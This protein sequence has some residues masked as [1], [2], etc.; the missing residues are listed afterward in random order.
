[1]TESNF[2]LICSSLPK[3]MHWQFTPPHNYCGF[4]CEV[5]TAVSIQALRAYFPYPHLGVTCVAV[6][7]PQIPEAESKI[8]GEVVSQ[9]LWWFA[10]KEVFGASPWNVALLSVLTAG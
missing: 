5:N 7:Y 6:T 9:P 3:R 2:G 8:P 1:M 10:Q 4:F